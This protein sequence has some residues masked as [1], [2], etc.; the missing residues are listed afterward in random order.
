KDIT[1]R[2]LKALAFL[3]IPQEIKMDNG[4][5]Y[6]SQKVQEFFNLWGVKHVTSI[7]HSSTGQSI[8]KGAH[9]T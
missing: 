8:I 6:S 2:F 9:R 7:S 1:K 5:A 3:G 4:P